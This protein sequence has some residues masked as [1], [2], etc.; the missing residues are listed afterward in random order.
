MIPSFAIALILAIAF[1][2]HAA[3]SPHS[4]AGQTM[5]LTRRSPDRTPDEWAAWAQAQ[6][7]S[8]RTKYGAAPSVARRGSG[9]NLIVNQNSDSAYYGSIAVGTPP[10]AFN[11]I[12]DTGSSD[13]WIADRRCVTG[14]DGVAKFD[15]SQ[16]ST[17]TNLT[18]SFSIK[19]GSG[20]A[21]GSLGQDVVQM[22][23]FSVAN[24]KFGV[25]DEVSSNLLYSPVSG[26]M[27]LAFSTISSSR[28][29]PFWEA[30]VQNGAWDSPVMSFQLTRYI[31]ENN[32]NTLEPGGT[33]TMGFVNQS[34]Y[35]GDID[36]QDIPANQE[37]YWLLP[38]TGLTVGNSAVALPTASSNLA[39]I[40]TGTTL[41]GG[42]SAIVS[43]LYAQI[44]GAVAGTG[45]YQDYYIYPCDTSVNVSMSFG[46]KSWS[47]SPQDFKLTPLTQTQCLG[48]IF[49][50]DISGTGSPAWIVG[51]TFLKN[52][53]SVFRYNPP[54]VGFAELSDTA[55]AMS[56]LRG[57]VPS[58]TLG[59]VSAEVT[60]NG[61]NT[62]SSTTNSAGR[63]INHW[64]PLRLIPMAL[65]IAFASSFVLVYL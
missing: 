44:P 28:S 35:T 13:L 26:L 57:T 32:A 41:V 37:S 16:S 30:L 65:S 56:N 46:G 4:S 11:V 22:A 12:L 14:C 27:G 61:G 60:A 58:P 10:V 40:D 59:A 63:S 5:H 25:C 48:A 21:A 36:F 38:L 18:T 19:Y 3:P 33:F 8:L 50:L 9:T 20:A 49:N 39:A 51:D 43:A 42:P 1:D 31:G 55:K 64:A 47:I 6:K 2:V 15:S 53:Y 29:T 62:V 45:N 17:F 34:L 52:V 24:Q 54:S 7:E 23:G